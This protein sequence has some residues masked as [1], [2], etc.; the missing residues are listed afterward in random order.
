MVVQRIALVDDAGALLRGKNKKKRRRG[1]RV[2][3]GGF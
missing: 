2:G 3:L 1:A